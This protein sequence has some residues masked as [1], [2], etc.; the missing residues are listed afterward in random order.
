MDVLGGGVLIV[1]LVVRLHSEV[2]DAVRCCLSP[3]SSIRR[4]VFSSINDDDGASPARP[5]RPRRRRRSRYT[6]RLVPECH[7]RADQPLLDIASRRG[8][9]TRRADARARTAGNPARKRAT[10]SARAMYAGTLWS[11]RKR[12]GGRSI[13]DRDRAHAPTR[14]HTPQLIAT[15]R[16]NATHD[17]TR[18]DTTTTTTTS[19]ANQAHQTANFADLARVESHQVARTHARVR[20]RALLVAS[21]VVLS[22][23]FPPELLLPPSL[24]RAGDVCLSRIERGTRTNSRTAADALRR[25]AASSVIVRSALPT[26]SLSRSSWFERDRPR[27]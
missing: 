7:A 20:A 5:R 9:E 6:Y 27:R 11:T 13:R 21:S 24:S 22:A 12:Q 4:A 2:A 14:T 19:I 23:L 17:S 25:N 16:V 18:H 15:P 3:S 26:E 1:G 10:P 8:A